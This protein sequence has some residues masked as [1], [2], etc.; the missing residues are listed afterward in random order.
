[1]SSLEGYDWATAR[2]E[3][4][5]GIYPALVARRLGVTES[6]VWT[7]AESEGWERPASVV[8]ALWQRELARMLEGAMP[9]FPNELDHWGPRNIQDRYSGRA[10][11]F[12]LVDEF[13]A[14]TIADLTWRSLPPVAWL[15]PIA[16]ALLTALSQV[17]P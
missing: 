6:Q 15:T 2:Q 3:F 9:S 4:E 8:E 10:A 17:T 1:M 13:F 11:R 7:F 14:S 16:F 12:V 5:S